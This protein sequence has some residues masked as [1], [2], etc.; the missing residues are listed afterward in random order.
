MEFVGVTAD[1][2]G[3][4]SGLARGFQIGRYTAAASLLGKP[5]TSFHSRREPVLWC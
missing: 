5:I 3:R 2:E 4:G 1:G